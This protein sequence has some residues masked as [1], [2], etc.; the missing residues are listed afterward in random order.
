[1]DPCLEILMI[2]KRSFLGVNLG[3]SINNLFSLRK[4]WS[5]GPVC[6]CFGFMICSP[7]LSDP[8]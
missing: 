7:Y 3:I 4:A 1:M 8:G 2:I 6:Y 5:P